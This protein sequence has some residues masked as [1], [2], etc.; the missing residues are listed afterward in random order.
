MPPYLPPGPGAITHAF[1]DNLPILLSNGWVTVYEM[2]AGYA[3]AVGVAHSA[4]H[5]HHLVATL[6]RNS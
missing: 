3:L 4:R 5:R 1:I 6:Q 2:V